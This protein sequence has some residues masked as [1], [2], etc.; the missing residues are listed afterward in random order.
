MMRNA[1]KRRMET[2]HVW[3][4]QHV[5]SKHRGYTWTEHVDT[6]T[7]SKLSINA[8][9]VRTFSFSTNTYGILDILGK[10]TCMIQTIAENISHICTYYTV[11]IKCVFKK[12]T[13]HTVGES[14]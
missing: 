11:S 1:A 10:C 4:T 14:S 3:G 12:S 5:S 9:Q 13:V 2:L 7:T 6:A 8:Y